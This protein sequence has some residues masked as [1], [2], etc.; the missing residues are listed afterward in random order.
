MDHSTCLA[1][2]PAEN[3]KYTVPKNKCHM[4]AQAESGERSK[5]NPGLQS[6]GRQLPG[7]MD[8]Q[9]VTQ[10]A[11]HSNWGAGVGGVEGRAF[12]SEEPVCVQRPGGN[13]G[14]ARAW[15]VKGLGAERGKQ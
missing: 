8:M 3:T 11:S 6:P 10:W 15:H 9:G 13:G 5:A 12:K 1:L 14:G 7:E 4:W 2:E